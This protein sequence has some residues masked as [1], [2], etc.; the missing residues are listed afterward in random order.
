MAERR[1]IQALRLFYF[2]GNYAQVSTI[3]TNTSA[4]SLCKTYLDHW[5]IYARVR[6]R[7]YICILIVVTE[8]GSF[9]WTNT[10]P[11]PDSSNRISLF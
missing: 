4:F 3:G 2:N 7:D 6:S 11:A 1:G 8:V 5:Y 10:L 9:P